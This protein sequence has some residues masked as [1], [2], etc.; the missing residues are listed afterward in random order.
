MELELE[1]GIGV[2]VVANMGEANFLENVPLAFIF[3]AVAELNGADRKILNYALA[4]L[5]LLRVVHVEVGL[6]NEVRMGWGMYTFKHPGT[7][8]REVQFCVGSA[9]VG[10]DELGR[11]VGYYGTQAILAGLAGWGSWLV[12][13]YWGY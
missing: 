1:L 5:L 2:M 10:F 8:R 4:T 9:D 6:R 3:A 13:G 11:P 12:K 7:F